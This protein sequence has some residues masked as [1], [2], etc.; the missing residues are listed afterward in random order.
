MATLRN[1]AMR[2]SLE[3]L[4]R[5]DPQRSRDRLASGFDPLHMRHICHGK[6]R[7]GFITLKPEAGALNLQHLYVEPAFQGCGAGTWALN[8][9]KNQGCDVRLSALKQS[10]A[11][12]FYQRHGFVQV[13]E[14][15]FDIHYLWSA[16][17]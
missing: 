2:E 12:R 11:N 16:A 14:E 15:E 8:W 3:R 17:R 13:G 7:I 1:V 4:N 9:A 10:A 6:R 5:F